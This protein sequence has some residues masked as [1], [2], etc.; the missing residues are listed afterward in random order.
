MET[1]FSLVAEFQYRENYAFDENGNLDTENP[2]WKMKGGH[3]M[4]VKEGMTVTEV[5]QLGKEGLQALVEDAVAT[6]E[7]VAPNG[8]CEYDLIDWMVDEQSEASLQIVLDKLVANESSG[9]DLNDYGYFVY[10]SYEMDMSE[11]NAH[12]LLSVLFDR[13]LIWW[14]KEEVYGYAPIALHPVRNL[15]AYEAA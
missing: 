12:Y 5:A 8:L 1:S 15:V 10:N 7:E 9:K 13:G 14:N 4:I 11:A 3:T 2:Y 6:R